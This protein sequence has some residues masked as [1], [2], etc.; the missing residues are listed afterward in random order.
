M[1]KCLHQSQDRTV[2]RGHMVAFTAY[3]LIAHWNDEQVDKL[4]SLPKTF[5]HAVKLYTP[6]FLNVL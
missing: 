4:A 2:Y 1:Q 5:I 6:F 3:F